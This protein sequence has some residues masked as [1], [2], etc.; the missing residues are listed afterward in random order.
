MNPLGL[1]REAQKIALD[2]EH[3]KAHALERRALTNCCSLKFVR[4]YLSWKTVQLHPCLKSWTN[5]SLLTRIC[6]GEEYERR[7]PCSLEGMSNARQLCVQCLPCPKPLLISPAVQG[8]CPSS[9]RASLGS[10][11]FLPE[12]IWEFLLIYLFIFVSPIWGHWVTYR[13]WADATLQRLKNHLSEGD[14]DIYV[15]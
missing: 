5:L 10:L 11:F 8:H 14:L 4:T 3:W 7:Q 9:S 12:E 13:Y 2:R 6:I 15:W 1:C